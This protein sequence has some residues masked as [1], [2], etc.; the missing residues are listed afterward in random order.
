MPLTRII[1]QTSLS[2]N[3]E[4]EKTKQAKIAKQAK[5]SASFIFQLTV[6]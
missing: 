1:S 3:M 2:R 4:E 6:L 5:I